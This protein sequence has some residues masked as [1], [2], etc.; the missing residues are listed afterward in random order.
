MA[1]W[2]Q[3]FNITKEQL[4]ELYINQNLKRAEV[5]EIYGCSDVLIKQ[6]VRLYGLQKSKELEWA[7]KRKTASKHCEQCGALFHSTPAKI[8]R[9]KY[10][11]KRC[12]EKGRRLNRTYEEQRAVANAYCAKQRAVRKAAYDPT[13]DPIKIAEFYAEAKRL[14]LE[15][16]VPHEVD[17]IHPLV[18]GGKHHEDN[19]QV[20]T[21]V[22]NR[23]KGGKLDWDGKV[24]AVNVRNK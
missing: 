20:L 19:L 3:Q 23:S 2:V 8:R 10:C 24:M 17:H 16:G 18:A 14:T 13:A 21:M 1:K 7:N 15:T 22:E 6:K 9:R 5:A 4:E 11:C 12:S